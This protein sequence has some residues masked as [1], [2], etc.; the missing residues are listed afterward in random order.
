MVVHT[1][2]MCTCGPTGVLEMENGEGLQGVYNSAKSCPLSV[3]RSRER[4]RELD[5]A[6]IAVE[7]GTLNNT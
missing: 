7:D 1:C 5:P 6:R 3:D 4:S 2:T